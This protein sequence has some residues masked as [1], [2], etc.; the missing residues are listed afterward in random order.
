MRLAAGLLAALA[1]PL[2][3]GPASAQTSPVCSADP[4]TLAC[5]PRPRQGADGILLPGFHAWFGAPTD[6]YGHGVLGDAGEWG[7]LY[8]I[9]QGSADHGP[10]VFGRVTLPASR[11]FEDIAPRLFDLDGDGTPEIVVVETEIA[12]GASLAV[13]DFTGHGIA[14]RAATPPIGR[15]NRWLAPIGAADL[16]GDGRVEIAY[17]ET[18]HLGRTL[19]IVRLERGKLVP[20]AEAGGLTNHRIGDPFIQGR[21][22][23][24]DGRPTILTAD[25]GWTRIVATAFENGR[26]ASRHLAPYLGPASLGNVPG[27]D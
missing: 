7:A 6:R 17:V 8:A 4:A 11:V 26:L 3:A 21:I 22:A 13:Y 16:D 23:I 20:V 10:Y 25:A 19:K 1:V 12:R 27:C 24:C 5:A 15:T 2:A 18:P 9:L 14:R